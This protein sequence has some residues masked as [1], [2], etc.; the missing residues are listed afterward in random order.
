MHTQVGM[1]IGAHTQRKARMLMGQF[2]RPLQEGVL[3]CHQAWVAMRPVA[4]VQILARLGSLGIIS[5]GGLH[6]YLGVKGRTEHAALEPLGAGAAFG[7]LA[8]KFHDPVAA[9]LVVHEP[10][11]LVQNE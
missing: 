10:I 11:R 8:E 1:H 7:K 5:R 4:L 6:S 9:L 3:D 2:M